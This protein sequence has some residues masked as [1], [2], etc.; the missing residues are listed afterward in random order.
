M[1]PGSPQ[2]MT[3]ALEEAAKARGKTSP[4]PMVGC[5]IAKRGA[6]IATAYHRRAGGAHAEVLALR[7][8]G[9][10][11]KNADVYVNLEPCDHQGRTG[12]C[13]DALVN[14]GVRR[15]FVAMRDPNPMVN[16]RGIRKL[17]RAGIEVV[18]GLLAEQARL[19]NEAFVHRMSAGR[20][21]VIAKI[22][23]SIDGC[24]A[25]RTG[26]SQWITGPASRR[27]G[28]RLRAE[29][30]AI[31]VGIGTVLADDPRLTCRV[32]GGADPIRVILDSAART[33]PKAAVIEAAQTSKAQTMIFVGSGVSSRRVRNLE[34]AGA[35][36]VA[37][38]EARGGVRIDEVLQQL[39]NL[40]ITSVLVEG[41]PTV[42]GSFVEANRIDKVHAFIAPMLIG[43]QGARGAVG[44]RG[45]SHLSDSL[46][47]ERVETDRCGEDLHLVG[48]PR[49]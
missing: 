21:F 33:P 19:L 27:Q 40:D 3:H 41:G 44:G 38:R 7:K 2:M 30:D 20:P 47:L 16:G 22:A 36:V 10:A 6:V 11:A 37:C 42:L 25:T 4:N 43:G 5:V 39:H 31:V 28:H 12:P 15:V 17:A 14:A 46:R 49:R 23:Q 26:E 45:I 8:A 1:P 9:S 32:R 48:Y 13:T 35:V 18:T 24:V 29:A 34:D